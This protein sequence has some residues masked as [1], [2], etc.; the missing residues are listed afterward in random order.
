MVE[1][2]TKNKTG[3]RLIHQLRSFLLPFGVAGVVPFFLV[4]RFNPFRLRHSIE[5]PFVQLPIG[6][7]LF[8]LGLFLLVITIRLIIRIGKGTL[9]PW[10]PTQKLVTEGIYGYVRNPMITGVAFLILGEAILFGALSLVIYLL[11]FMIINTLYFKISEEPGLAKRFGDDYR[12]YRKNVR[13]W[14]PR[15]RAWHSDKDSSPKD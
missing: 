5:F 1:V 15:L 7:V 12:E 9:A 11:A 2:S 8:L 13:M 4:V 14:I 3:Y 6:L 10:N